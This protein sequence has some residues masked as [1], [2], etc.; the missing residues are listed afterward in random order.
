MNLYFVHFG[1]LFLNSHEV[2]FDRDAAFLPNS[3]R[4]SVENQPRHLTWESPAGKLMDVLSGFAQLGF[5]F[6][7]RLAVVVITLLSSVCVAEDSVLI[8][9]ALLEGEPVDGV[10]QIQ[11]I[12]NLAINDNGDWIVECNTDFADTDRDS[13][14]VKNGEL[15]LRE[16]SIGDINFPANAFIDIF[17]SVNINNSGNSGINLFIDPLPGDADSGV[18]LNDMLMIQE[19]DLVTADGITVGTPYIGFFDT[20][21]NNLDEIM[22]MVSVDDPKIA[23]TVD[24]AIIV[25]STTS[26]D[27]NLVCQGR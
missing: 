16:G 11:F 2:A 13:V 25:L 10:G 1:P 24:R 21:I 22:L 17:D 20:K 5:V 14:L 4:I 18:Y 26:G 23:S 8:T 19:G 9:A 27:Q 7:S 12:D 15:F 6:M 3:G